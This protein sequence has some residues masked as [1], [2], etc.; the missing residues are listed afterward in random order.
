MNENTTPVTTSQPP[1]RIAAA[2]LR[3]LRGARHVAASTATSAISAAGR[4]QEISVP[5]AVPNSRPMPVAPPNEAFWP[6]PEEP[7]EEP[8]A[9]PP[10]PPKIRPRPLY[11]SASC[12]SELL[13]EPAM[14]GRDDVGH[15]DTRATYQPADTSRAAPSISRCRIRLLRPVGA[16]TRYTSAN[17]GSTRNACIILVRNPKPSST[18]VSASQRQL[19]FS[20]ART[21]VYAPAVISS[22]SSASGLSYRNI[23]TAT[24]V[25]ASTRP[26]SRPATGPNQRRTAAYSN[27][28]DATPMSACGARI[29]QL[30][31][32]NRRADRPITHRAAGGLSTVI[33]LPAS[34]EP[35]SHA[36]QLCAP[37]WAAA[38]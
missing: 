16:A 23:S 5:M 37:A 1:Q 28:T 14:Y 4:S 22:V 6:P 18:P 34:S 26:A 21:V 24:G 25:T 32:P 13:V 20:T 33:A 7:P 31:T 19:A 9:T 11:P 27:P 2:R 38:A 30:F 10:E 36:F 15:S 17:A 12:H 3:S 29:D 8:P 35:N